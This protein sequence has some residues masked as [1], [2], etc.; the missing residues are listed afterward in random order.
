LSAVLIQDF[1]KALDLVERNFALQ[2]F[3]R[4]EQRN[5]AHVIFRIRLLVAFNFRLIAF[6]GGRLRFGC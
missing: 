6:G 5:V 3:Q 1:A 2:L 4:R